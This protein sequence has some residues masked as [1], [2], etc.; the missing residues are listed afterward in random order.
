MKVTGL[1]TREELLDPLK[2]C[3]PHLPGILE[4]VIAPRIKV[5][6]ET[7]MDAYA[8]SAEI[9]EPTWN[10]GRGPATRPVWPAFLTNSIRMRIQTGDARASSR[11]RA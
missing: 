9:P 10:T 7:L 4:P 2:E 1:S 11:S 3:Y 8:A 5:K 6:I